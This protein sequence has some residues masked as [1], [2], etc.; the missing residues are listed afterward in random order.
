[1][2]WVRAVAP[3]YGRAGACRAIIQRMK[4]DPRRPKLYPH[5]PEFH[6]VISMLNAPFI[7]SG[8]YSSEQFIARRI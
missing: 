1:M 6:G 3:S 5:A 4:A 8:Q 7:F 2:I